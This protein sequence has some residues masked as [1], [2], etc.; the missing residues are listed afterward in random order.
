MAAQTEGSCDG[1]EGRGG[2]LLLAGLDGRQVRIRD[3]GPIC[4]ILPFEPTVGS[5]DLDAH[6]ERNREIAGIGGHGENSTPLGMF[7]GTNRLILDM[8]CPLRVIMPPSGQ[9]TSH[10]CRCREVL[11]SRPRRIHMTEIKPPVHISI[12]LDRSGSM[13]SI[14]DDIVGGFNEYLDRQ[15][16]EQGEAPRP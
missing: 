11:M 13:A 7:S 2:R 14:A 16:R 9:D 8:C 12:V 15:K 1:N 5:Q 10:F 3:P 4:K 6:S